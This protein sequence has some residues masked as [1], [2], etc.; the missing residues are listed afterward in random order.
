VILIPLPP[1]R[2]RKEDIPLLI[3]HFLKL[4]GG[5][6][7]VTA[8]PGTVL[9]ALQRYDWPG[10]VRELQNVLQRYLTV[11]S[12]DFLPAQPQRAWD[13]SHAAYA[14]PDSVQNLNETLLQF[15][16]ALILKALDQYKGNKTKAAEALGIDRRSL[17]RKM[18]KTG[19]L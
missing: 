6:K 8:L 7:K 19:I 17:F 14:V 11:K 2:E 4:Y 13:S 12:L 1:L 16:K 9:D 18:E 10:N 3:E 15:E 5:Q